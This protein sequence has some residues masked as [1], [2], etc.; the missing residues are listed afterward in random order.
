MPAELRISRSDS[1]QSAPAASVADFLMLAKARCCASQSGP[2][3][4]L[5][6]ERMTSDGNCGRCREAGHSHGRYGCQAV[7][8]WCHGF[9]AAEILDRTRVDQWRGDTPDVSVSLGCGRLGTGDADAHQHPLPGRDLFLPGI[10]IPEG[11][12]LRKLA[13]T[14]I[15]QQVAGA[16]QL[17]LTRRIKQI[18]RSG[19]NAGMPLRSDP[20]S[21]S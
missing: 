4:R 14:Q 5:T 8:R 10:S 18:I 13:A 15:P 17:R 16:A 12:G 6:P 21:R 3:H 20:R 9:R 2:V 1:R 19:M 7:G 11:V